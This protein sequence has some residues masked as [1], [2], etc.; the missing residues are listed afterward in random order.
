MNMNISIDR[1]SVADG[2]NKFL[3]EITFKARRGKVFGVL[4]PPAAG[5]TTLIH[6]ILGFIHC[7]EGGVEFDGQ[8]F[9]GKLRDRIGYLPERRGVYLNQRLIDVLVYFGRLKNLSPKKAKIEAIRLLDRFG[10]IDV[11]EKTVAR[12][13][14]DLQ[15]KLQILITI[16]HEPEA[17]ILDEPFQ[18]LHPLNRDLMRKLIYRFRDEEKTV[19]L[20]T[21]QFNEAEKLC[22]DVLLL[23]EGKQLL[24]GNLDKLRENFQA[25]IITVETDD[26][27]T[28][29]KQIRGVKKFFP[30]KQSA[31]LFVDYSLPP[32]EIL[33][34]I[35]STV[36]VNKIEVSRPNLSDIFFVVLNK[37]E[38][39]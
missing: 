5:K 24:K 37:A 31:K 25:H 3:E 4:G 18:E 35:I 19:V 12:L 38:A 10:M 14:K 26:N 27:L 2:E 13:S 22:D 1:L 29:L 9:S 28:A 21:N 11:M 36:N 23:N 39:K 16:I 20:S 34:K 33:Q 7:E 8:P 15:E 6:A 32:Q 17:L 30:E